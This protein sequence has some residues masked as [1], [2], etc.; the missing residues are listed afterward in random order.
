MKKTSVLLELVSLDYFISF[1]LG[2]ANI[3]YKLANHTFVYIPK[4]H[5]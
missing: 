3:A 5:N 4:P 2:F 1:V